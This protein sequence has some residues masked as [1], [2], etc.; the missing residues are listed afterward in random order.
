MAKRMKFSVVGLPHYTIWHLYEPSVDDI[1]HMEEME[2]ERKQREAEEKQ[3]KERAEKIQN[4]FEVAA[5]KTQW[6]K[7]K[8]QMK[9]MTEAEAA[10]RA[11]KLAALKAEA[12]VDKSP[13][14]QHAPEKQ[15]EEA[16]P[17]NAG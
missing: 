8:E 3:K 6:E 10:K 4:Q 1:R 2:Q 14:G 12:V 13:G 16:A 11:A 7:D 9:G 5:D 17:Q 15:A